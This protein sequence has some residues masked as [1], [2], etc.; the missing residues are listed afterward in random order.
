M[1]TLDRYVDLKILEATDSYVVWQF[2]SFP[3]KIITTENI[4]DNLE[5]LKIYKVK[6]FLSDFNRI[7]IDI[8]I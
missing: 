5:V 6:I 4:W 7:E 1:P 2:N 3:Y 8:L